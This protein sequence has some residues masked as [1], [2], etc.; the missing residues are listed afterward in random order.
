M[1]HSNICI[2]A[3]MSKQFSQKNKKHAPKAKPQFFLEKQNPDFFE[4]K[5]TFFSK[6]N[7]IFFRN[8]SPI[9]F[10]NKTPIFLAKRQTKKKLKSEKHVNYFFIQFKRKFSPTLTDSMTQLPT[11]FTFILTS[12]E[13][14]YCPSTYSSGQRGTSGCT[15]TVSTLPSSVR[16]VLNSVRCKLQGEI[17]VC[18]KFS[19]RFTDIRR[20]TNVRW[21]SSAHAKSKTAIFKL[22]INEVLPFRRPQSKYQIACGS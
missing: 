9:F 2:N 17:S 14:E 8:K 18:D 20:K 21:P 6:Q 16:K 4:N 5:T 10:Q 7:S 11:I 12:F 22:S 15:R 3:W 1:L 13:T 19:E